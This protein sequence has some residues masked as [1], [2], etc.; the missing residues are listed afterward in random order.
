M[1]QHPRSLFDKVWD[2]HLVATRPD[3]QALLAIDRHFLHE[4]SFHAFGMIDHA[5]RPVRRPELTF[6]VADHY[7]PSHSRAKPIADPEIANMVTMLEANAE[8]HGLR[9][10]GLHDPAQGIVHVLAPE[11]GLTLPGLTIVCGDSHTSTHG[12][13]GALAFGI[14][15]TEVS[16]VLAT[17]TLW[18][19]RPKTMRIIIDGELGA[20]VTAKDLILAVIG[21]IGADGAAGHVIEYAGSAIRALSMEGR[22]T[23]CNMSIE[24]GA[25]AGMI[26][27]DDITFSWIEGRNYAP[28]GDLFDRAVAHWRTLPSDPEAEIGRAHV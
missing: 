2:A 15:A 6:A 26:A 20:H 17:Q 18:Q 12:A 8:R 11:Q 16:H 7:V 1:T 28:K 3:G 10:F 5:K 24:A 19:R 25:R 21:F 14:G 22:L 9:H 27:P 23:V 13:F 4:G